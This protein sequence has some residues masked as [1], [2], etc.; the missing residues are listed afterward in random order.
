MVTFNPEDMMHPLCECRYNI[1]TKETLN[2]IVEG[3]INPKRVAEIRQAIIEGKPVWSAT[4]MHS[5]L[6]RARKFDLDN[7]HMEEI[8]FERM[9]Q[10]EPYIIRTPDGFPN[11][12]CHGASEK[13]GS[14][15]YSINAMNRDWI[16]IMKT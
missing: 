8:D 16:T 3:K 11:G 4:T 9:L 15:R 6:C 12:K 1:F 13:T 5:L 10:E 2:N 7:E 14:S